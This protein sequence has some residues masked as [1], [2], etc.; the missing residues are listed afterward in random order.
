MTTNSERDVIEERVLRQIGSAQAPHRPMPPYLAIS[1]PARVNLLPVDRPITAA[2]EAG[3]TAASFLADV[4]GYGGAMDR[5]AASHQVHA[6]LRVLAQPYRGSAAFRNSDL[7]SVGARAESWSRTMNNWL[8]I[9]HRA[10][11]FGSWWTA[12][13]VALTAGAFMLLASGHLMAAAGLLVLRI[14][15]SM[16][17]PTPGLSADLLSTESHGESRQASPHWYIDWK[18][19]VVGQVCDLAMTVAVAGYLLVNDRVAWAG[20]ACLVAFLQITGTMLR[21]AA[22]QQGVVLRRLFLERLMRN[23]FLL[24]GVGLAVAFQPLVPPTGIPLIALSVIGSAAYAL[25]EISRVLHT[26]EAARRVDDDSTLDEMVWR[27]MAN[28]LPVVER[29]AAADVADRPEAPESA[30]RDMV[31]NF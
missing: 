29:S 9:A 24:L 23:G 4:R 10:R 26:T 16:L 28:L 5:R 25:V 31:A 19:C 8:G 13:R 20:A 2:G 27:R 3:C 30:E 6:V 1:I 11:I 7:V 18:A 14:L 12:A 15:G 17:Q 22:V 21:I